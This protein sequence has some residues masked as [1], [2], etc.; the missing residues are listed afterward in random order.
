[1]RRIVS[2]ATG[3][4]VFIFLAY[5]GLSQINT[6]RPGKT[7][8][9]D[10]IWAWRPSAISK[11]RETDTP[12]IFQGLF[13]IADNEEI[14][15]FQGVRP[16]QVQRSEC[17]LVL[18]YRLEDL[19]PAEM[20]TARY[21]VHRK[22]WQKKG[23][24]VAGLQIDFDSPSARLESYATW[25]RDLRSTL[26]SDTSFS[27]TG[28]PDW[29]VSAPENDLQ[30]VALQTDFIAFMMYQGITPVRDPSPYYAALRSSN[31]QFKI[32]LLPTQVKDQYIAQIRD[33][34]GF[35]GTFIFITE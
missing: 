13:S 26:P 19:V 25:L 21:R 33:L 14:Y 9:E 27:I 12:H 1:M 29:L 2:G 11:L 17:D 5:A 3:T 18:T 28:L 7:P 8:C 20:I 16:S 34:P 24:R 10:G 31:L 32:G 22:V 6:P 30:S 15:Q 23:N 35:I 4:A